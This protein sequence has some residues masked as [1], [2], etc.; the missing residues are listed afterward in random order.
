MDVYS[1]AINVSPFLV[2]HLSGSQTINYFV[3]VIDIMKDFLKVIDY[4][5]IGLPHHMT[6]YFCRSEERRVGKEC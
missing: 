3:N 2:E 1:R 4:L 5:K 6:S